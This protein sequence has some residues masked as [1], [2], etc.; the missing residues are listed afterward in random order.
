M[1]HQQ[2]VFEAEVAVRD[3][4]FF[5]V[6][7]AVAELQEEETHTALIDLWLSFMERLPRPDKVSCCLLRD[8]R[9]D[10]HHSLSV[11]LLARRRCG[12]LRQR[13]GR[14]AGQ[15]DFIRRQH[16]LGDASE[17]VATVLLEVEVGRNA[18]LH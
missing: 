4:V 17:E 1:R 15:R 3:P 9:G 2:Q 18:L 5:Q 10:D 11:C 12:G 14:C 13:W 16:T 8:L 6:L 7:Q